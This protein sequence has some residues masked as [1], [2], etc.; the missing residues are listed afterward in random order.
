MILVER[1]MF[2]DISSTWL[3]VAHSIHPS[4]MLSESWKHYNVCRSMTPVRTLMIN[5]PRSHPSLDVRM[6]VAFLHPRD[7]FK[8][9]THD[10][11]HE[12]YQCREF[13]VWLIVMWSFLPA[14][15]NHGCSAHLMLICFDPPGHL[16]QSMSFKEYSMLLWVQWHVVLFCSLSRTRTNQT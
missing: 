11:W 14:T 2:P 16:H 4:E 3:R 6:F 1:L 7:G 15:Y 9:I 5:W 8:H 10:H 12:N 13:W